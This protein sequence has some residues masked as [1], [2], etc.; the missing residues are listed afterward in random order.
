MQKMSSRPIWTGT[1]TFGLVTIPVKLFTAV[2]EQAVHFRSLHDQD[3]VPLKQKLYC[4]ADGSDVHPEHIVKGY[5]IE[6]DRYVVV[7][8]E[9]IEA[10][11]PKGNKS[12]E[13]EDFVNLAEIDPLYFDRPYYVMPKPEGVKPYNLLLAAMEETGRVGIARVVLFRKEHLAA[14]RPLSG[15]L[16]LETMHYSDEVVAA[17]TP[18]AGRSKVNDRELRVARQLI[19]SLSGSFDPGKYKDEYRQAILDLVARKAQGQEV[20]AATPPVESRKASAGDLMAVLEASVARAKESAGKPA[21]PAD[22]EPPPARRK[23]KTP[24]P[25]K[26]RRTRANKGKARPGEGS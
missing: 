22:E 24:T 7:R 5:E 19:E 18:P 3:Q 26:V 1:I 4:P 15:V 13:I 14:L 2:R 9:E 25:I 11:A 6:K 21:A 23:T 16:C 17:D 10:A 20:T 8:D 12:I